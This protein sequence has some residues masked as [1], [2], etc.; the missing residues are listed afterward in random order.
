MSRR[1]GLA[2]SLFALGAALGSSVAAAKSLEEC[3]ILNALAKSTG[4]RSSRLPAEANPVTRVARGAQSMLLAPLDL[5][6]TVINT[7]ARSGLITGM[8]TGVIQGTLYSFS[9]FAAG[10]LDV[11]TAPFPGST[12]PP[13]T[14]RLGRPART[15]PAARGVLYTGP[16]M[17]IRTR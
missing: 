6:A 3:P 12:L 15:A 13:Y 11:I 10:G 5:P 7:T 16:S 2:L 4:G 8:T 14:R 9:R 17:R 1:F